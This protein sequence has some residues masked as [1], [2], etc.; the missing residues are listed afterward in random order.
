MANFHLPSI[1]QVETFGC[2]PFLRWFFVSSLLHPRIDL[3]FVCTCVCV[4]V[5]D[6]KKFKPRLFTLMYN[7]VEKQ[8]KKWSLII[9]CIPTFF[10]APIISAFLC[11]FFFSVVPL[12]SFLPTP[13]VIFFPISLV[14]VFRSCSSFFQEREKKFLSFFF[15]YLSLSSFFLNWTWSDL[16]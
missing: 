3:S 14:C 5:K 4:C 15:F 10:T 1:K 6:K 12:L 16:T 2:S 13:R 8:K 9:P 7:V 11:M